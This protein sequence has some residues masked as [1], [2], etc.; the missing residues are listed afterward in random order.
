M[1]QN[2]GAAHVAMHE[3][4]WHVTR[5]ADVERPTR[6]VFVG[7]GAAGG[8]MGFDVGDPLAAPAEAVE[9]EISFN[10][11]EAAARYYLDQLLG[12]DERPALQE[13]TAPNEPRV[14]PDLRLV[15]T[16]DL[17]GTRTKVLRF[18]QLQHEIPVFGTR[19]IVE[20]DA[21]R[22]A[23]SVGAELAEVGNV[24]PL[25]TI[26]PSDA[27]KR[28]AAILK[29]TT[30]ALADVPPPTLTFYKDVKREVWHLA[31]LFLGVPGPEHP[32]ATDH[33]MAPSPRSASPR[34]NVLLRATGAGSL[35]FRYGADPTL[36]DV[37]VQCHGLD[38]TDQ[39]VKFWGRAVNGVFRLEDA[40]R[41]ALTFDLQF[42]DLATAPVPTNA[43]S[44]ATTDWG[45]EHR[46]AISAHYNAARVLDFYNS[47]LLRDG[48]DGR[49]MPLVSLVNC[50]Y[51]PIGADQ[52]WANAVWYKDRMWYGQ[53][54]D[55]GLGRLASYSR[56][57]DVIAH[58]LTHGVTAY[59][60]KLVYQGE[61]GALNESFSDIFGVII[62]N[63][64]RHTDDGGS[65]DTWSWQIGKGLA[66]N[67]GP[68]RDLRDPA[69]L[70]QPAHMKDFV[71]TTR[72]NG[73]VHTNSNIHNKAA[74]NVLT[75]AD[76]NGA[77]VFTPFDVATYYYWTL[78]R[79]NDQATFVKTLEELIDVVSSNHPD[80]APTRDRMVGAIT[81]AYGAVGIGV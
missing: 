2:E 19:A 47:V 5:D 12:R 53:K 24:S 33:G 6:T 68:L 18:Q 41:K 42:G 20:L 79:L 11:D 73:G 38:E 23:R 17:A 21:D 3:L 28:L 8:P 72:D 44:S 77:R 52:S 70:G 15:E 59:T 66:S 49:S 75:A 14:V 37:P 7:G 63:W 61:S 45:D 13:L 43:I 16:Y 58:E 71:K 55:S 67:G 65:V 57:L 31:F 34:L 80:D 78:E 32:K 54:A 62:S 81:A 22:H 10:T 25:A 35:L 40:Q 74:Y 4:R 60:S 50:R 29:T 76:A 27:V 26:S 1:G 46:A 56:F 51:R 39:N 30:A 64:D 48:V 9:V 36:A 69:S